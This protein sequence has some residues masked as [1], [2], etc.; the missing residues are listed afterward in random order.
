[1]S[2]KKNN[3]LQTGDNIH[4]IY[5]SRGAWVYGKIQITGTNANINTKIIGHGILDG[6][7]FNFSNRHNNNIDGSAM[8]EPITSSKSV[9]LIGL[10]CHN[11]SFFTINLSPNSYA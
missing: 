3:I 6:S 1:M 5:I 7:Y 11:P 9:S 2:N 10:T 4:T 8:I